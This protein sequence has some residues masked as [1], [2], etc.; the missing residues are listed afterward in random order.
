MASRNI[1]G[2]QR[3]EE[4]RAS[5]DRRDLR[6]FREKL[7]D[8]AESTEFFI[9][10]SAGILG[11]ILFFPHLA[12]VVVLLAIL[13]FWWLGSQKFTLSFRLPI[14]SRLH[15]YND[16]LPGK[17]T[18]AKARGI[19]FLG[20]EM[21][22]SRELWFNKS[23]MCT[24]ILVFGST[25]AGKALKD[26]ED[27]LTTVGW[28][29]NKD[30]EV[31]DSVITPDGGHAKVLEIH[32]QGEKPLWRVDFDDGRWIETTSDHL[33]GVRRV[34]DINEPGESN[35]VFSTGDLEAIL[36]NNDYRDN[37][38]VAIPI[39]E[40]VDGSPFGFDIDF[41]SMRYQAVESL[42][43][44]SVPFP[45]KIISGTLNQRINIWNMLASNTEVI[46]GEV[47]FDSHNL[48]ALQAI[49]R[50][51]WSLGKW[52][53]IEHWDNSTGENLLNISKGPWSLIVKDASWLKITKITPIYT[54]AQCRCIKIDDP[55]G[56]FV[57]KDWI[58]T[59]NTETLI[60]LAYNTLTTGSGFIYVDGKGDNSLWAKIFSVARSLGREDDLLVINF[61]TGGRDMTVKQ[62]QKPSNTLNPFT[63][64]S[65]A[66]L[67]ELLVGLMDE[68]GGDGAMWKGRAISLI[69]AIMLA[70]VWLRDNAGLLLDVDQIREYLVLDNIQALSKRRD[71]P[72]NA[73]K[74]INAYLKSLPGYV[75]GAPKQSE[76]V[77]DQHGYLQMQFT[78]ILG[79]L[80]E[81]YGH[82]F[83][84]NLGEVDFFDVILNRR[85]LVVLLPA[86]EKS[87]D[88]L[89]NLGKIIVGCLKQ[90]MAT[91]LGDIL[92]GDYEDV[93][94]RKPTNSPAPYMVILDEYGYYVVKGASV[95][96]AQ[97]RSL[98]FSMVFAGQDYPAFKK[99]NNQ[100]EAVS[101]IGNCNIKIFMKLEDPTET[102]DLAEKSIGQATIG[103]SSG[104]SR[105]EGSSTYRDGQGAQVDRRA[106]ADWLDFKDHREGEAHII[107]KST[108]V[109]ANMFFA[110]ASKVKQMQLNSFL[111]VEPPQLSSM[112]E[113]DDSIE[114]L[115]NIIK[116]PDTANELAEGT[117][118]T[119]NIRFKY[120]A[121]RLR[122]GAKDKSINA[123][124]VGIAALFDMTTVSRNTQNKIARSAQN[125]EI[126]VNLSEMEEAGKLAGR[127]RFDI[128]RRD[129]EDDI[130]DYD[131]RILLDHDEVVADLTEI[132][133]ALGADIDEASEMSER[134]AHDLQL[135]STYPRTVPDEIDTDE[136]S[137]MLGE[138]IEGLND[139]DDDE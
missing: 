85:I 56:L 100:E 108:L 10:S 69:S 91:G 53:K 27:I 113:E 106:R 89:A 35:H 94:E 123:N 11:F 104:L 49:Q 60:S 82:I 44:D 68:A 64:G 62:A 79:S 30:I 66:G 24:H 4:V 50:L 121:A 65:A 48:N 126:S 110:N 6:P 26:D 119:S 22:S 99:N 17:G 111:R 7:L 15:D 115:I 129:L 87:T 76:T 25:G 67:T 120:A 39:A 136:Y 23:D 37:G 34:K 40:P 109:R 112:K 84:T 127:G 29:K 133:M 42:M 122:D 78:R 3:K 125:E 103:K 92:E 58:V 128:T 59:H 88:E 130:E 55:R 9:F 43:S 8:I 47:I 114:E 5:L 139:D 75:E 61:M 71:L 21:D 124:N 117:L 72:P 51:A 105:K 116:N 28:K 31:G 57:T 20:N 2:V 132:E 33:W 18:P 74:A 32:P 52:A 101:T 36:F 38:F 41:R 83:R 90:M 118:N 12:E 98:G 81:T 16:P 46:C 96:P 14:G 45:E 138:L 107:F 54:T 137:E 19:A 80:S 93:I 95:M 97:A 70:L 102:Y 1:R 73:Q 134:V 13:F 63:T 77:T 86:M 131:E 135:V